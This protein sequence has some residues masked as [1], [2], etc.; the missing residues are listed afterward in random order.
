MQID[1]TISLP[2]R[3]EALKAFHE[4]PMTCL[5]MTLGTGA[6]GYFAC[7]MVDTLEYLLT[8]ADLT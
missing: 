8:D 5:L 1:G 7:P 3:H 4:D 6:V 2:A